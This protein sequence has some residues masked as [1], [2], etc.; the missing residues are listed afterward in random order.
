MAETGQVPSLAKAKLIPL[1]DKGAESDESKHIKVQFNPSSLKVTL[2]NT[3][4]ADS[5]S[6][7]SGTAAQFVDKSSSSLSI[8]LMFD[9]TVE[10]DGVKANTDVRLQTQK[11]AEAFMKPI[12]GS[13]N[14]MLAPARCRFQ[15]GAFKFIGMVGSYNETLDF[16]SPEGIP[17]RARLS[18]SLKEDKYQFERDEQ[19]KAKRGQL[20][21]FSKAVQDAKKKQT[22]D[23]QTMNEALKSEGKDEAKFR[24]TAM[25]NGVEDTRQLNAQPLQ[26]AKNDPAIPETRQM[27]GS[28]A[29]PGFSQGNSASLGSRIPG[30]F[31]QINKTSKQIS[32][33]ALR[34]QQARQKIEQ[35]KK[36]LQSASNRIQD[37]RDN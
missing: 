3:L 29:S 8:E 9:T 35:T 2:A 30:A 1:D 15:W 14:K 19:V 24:N 11:I 20:P 16:F 36:R 18:L 28:S 33:A 22:S 25:A 23:N 26:V 32:Q 13:D 7:D 12:E 17:L 34:V 4:K 27:D 31:S 5:K 6:N 37:V 10:F 21:K